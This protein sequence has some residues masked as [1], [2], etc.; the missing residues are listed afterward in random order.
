MNYRI[1]DIITGKVTGI[2]PYGVFV[3]LDEH[4]QGLIHI[5]E[6]QHGFVKALSELFKVGERVSVVILDIDEFSGKIS[7]S[8]RALQLAPEMTP[9]RRRKHY[10]TSRKVH[11]GFAPIAAHLS[12]W[13]S[14]Y[15]EV[16]N[17]QSS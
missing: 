9:N 8:V 7:L 12:G 13:V 6:C 14:E 11:N 2:Q 1:G 5:S 4:H 15:L 17:K 10:W 3:L 16:M